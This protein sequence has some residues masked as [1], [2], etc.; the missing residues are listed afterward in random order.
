M[1]KFADDYKTRSSA[2]KSQSRSL[3][4]RIIHHTRSYGLCNCLVAI[5]FLR[6]QELSS[7]C[8]GIN[9][10]LTPGLEDTY[11]VIY[12]LPSGRKR[13]LHYSRELPCKYR[14][15]PSKPPTQSKRPPNF[16]SKSCIGWHYFTLHKSCLHQANPSPPPPP[17]FHFL[18]QSLANGQVCNTLRYNVQ[19]P[20]TQVISQ[21]RPVASPMCTGASD[22]T[23]YTVKKSQAS[24]KPVANVSACWIV[25][26]GEHMVTWRTQPIVL[27]TYNSIFDQS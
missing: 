18:G 10:V 25:F 4:A 12:L 16:G 11:N 2:W 3:Y 14:K 22:T 6:E 15:A 23:Q 21:P 20:A 8:C 27:E 24:C 9:R 19:A 26:S 13:G 7:I 1:A 17:P 5:L